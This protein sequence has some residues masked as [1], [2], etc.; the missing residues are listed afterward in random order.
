MNCR[1]LFL[2]L[3]L[4]CT[5]ETISVKGTF[6]IPSVTIVY[7]D[8]NKTV[9]AL[10]S[11]KHKIDGR[12]VFKHKRY[13][14]QLPSTFRF[15][16]RVFT[17]HIDHFVFS[18]DKDVVLVAFSIDDREIS[19]MKT[20]EIHD[21]LDIKRFDFCNVLDD[22]DTSILFFSDSIDE[23]NALIDFVND[24]GKLPLSR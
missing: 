20:T 5:R 21:K 8:E 14:L 22:G 1:F 17:N 10:P 12:T 19:C 13:V 16:K 4:G 2:L 7:Y 18:D 6:S 9:F 11:I 24:N 3:I 23:T 15:K